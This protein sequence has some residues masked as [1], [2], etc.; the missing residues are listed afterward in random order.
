[1]E[2][3]AASESRVHCGQAQLAKAALPGEAAAG[4]PRLDLVLAWPSSQQN[5]L[6]ATTPAM[7]PSCVHTRSGCV[8]RASGSWQW[9]MGC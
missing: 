1:M 7:L 9:C 5:V 4:H 2:P 6:W 8:G 3:Q